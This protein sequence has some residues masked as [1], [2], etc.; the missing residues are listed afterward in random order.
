MLIR[1][2][3]VWISKQRC[4]LGENPLW[5]VRSGELYWI[6]IDEAAVFR[7]QD[8]KVRQYPCPKP[9]GSIYLADPGWL[10]VAMRSALAWLNLDSG[11]LQPVRAEA[12]IGADERFND[13]RC[14]HDGTFW[15]S[16]LD[17]R[18]EAPIGSIVRFDTQF[19]GT[20]TPS[21]AII[22]NGICFS[23]DD[24]HLYFSDSRGRAI[25]RYPKA[26]GAL[27]AR[28]LFAALDGEPGRPD[29]CTVD[30]QGCLWSARIG[31]GRIDRYAPEGR[32]VDSLQLPV[33]DPTHCTFGG[34]DLKTL[35]VTTAQSHTGSASHDSSLAGAVLAFELD[36]QGMPEHRLDAGYRRP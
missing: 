12:A 36:A 20:A 30:A 17:R 11:T 22:G 4:K 25:Y 18:V 13:G 9:V 1:K 23:N 28:T 5:D 35:F 34:P 29:G 32:L 15:I 16:T 26:D 19:K 24:A 33:A 6:N 27:G 14:D 10:L 3:P 31:G 21:Q 8:G 2:T 7:L